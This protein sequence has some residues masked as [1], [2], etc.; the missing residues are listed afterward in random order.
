ML[1]S[2]SDPELYFFGQLGGLG[3]VGGWVVGDSEVKA[4]LSLSLKLKLRLSMAI[5]CN[6]DVHYLQHKHNL[7]ATYRC[8]SNAN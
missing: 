1:L 8:N 6:L 4:N 7:D 5:R 3:G 2:F